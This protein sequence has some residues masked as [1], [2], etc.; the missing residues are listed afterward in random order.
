[1]IRWLFGALVVWLLRKRDGGATASAPAAA[2]EPAG[3][4]GPTPRRRRVLTVIALGLGVGLA[5]VLVLLSGLVPVT[6]SGGHFALTEW[7]LQLG[8]RRSV[9]THTIGMVAP[10]GF[11]DR[12]AVLK[13]AGHYE[14]GCA[15]CH[16]SPALAPPRVARAMLPPPP[17]LAQRVRLWEAEELF[18]I[19]KHGI[20]L[21][22]MPAWPAPGRDDE[23]WAMVA[24]LRTLP[25]T[26]APTYRRLVFGAAAASGAA[27]PL[28][29]LTAAPPP[30]RLVAT[31]ARCHGADGQGRGEG[32]FPRLAGQR[33]A[34]LAAALTAYARDQRASGVM[35][36]LAAPLSATEVRALA[37]HYARLPAAAVPVPDDLAAI[38]RGR[39]IAHAGSPARKLPACAD[40]HGPGDEPRNEHYPRLAGQYSD[41]L[42]LQLDLLRRGKR[43][44]SPYAHVMQA[45]AA[46]LTPADIA[47]V[48]AYYG[49]AALPGRPDRPGPLTP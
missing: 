36:P 34:Y 6:A 5:A 21:T 28:E 1:M 8:K 46:R 10:A 47:D 41:Y 32:A 33:E 39:Q 23:V 27:V 14:L 38:A 37:A 20:K 26:D 16:G 25:G 19:V 7:V 15:P 3:Q 12:A 29:D 45:I 44:G 31:C 35:Q 11:V 9:A 18:Y 48:A 13:G 42:A 22:G 24:F 49:A 40:C 4:P 43:G 2:P 17:D 30:T